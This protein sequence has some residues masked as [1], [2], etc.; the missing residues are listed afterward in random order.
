[1]GLSVNTPNLTNAIVLTGFSSN[2]S[3][4]GETV[5]SWDTQ[6]ASVNQPDR[7]GDLPYGYLTWA[8]NASNEYSFLYPSGFDPAILTY[9]EATKGPYTIGELFTMGGS[10]TAANYTGPVMVVTGAEDKIFC[11]GD[12]Y[13]TGGTNGT[14]LDVVSSSF[15]AASNFTTFLPNATGHGI[16]LHYGGKPP[17]IFTHT[18]LVY[19]SHYIYL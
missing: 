16:N 4:M 11:G 19:S 14:I 7:F 13:A 12:C 18:P 9:D 10:A 1:M 2:S 5:A 15:P 6:L 3:F 8:S 17:S